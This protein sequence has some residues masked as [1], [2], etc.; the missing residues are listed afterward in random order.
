MHEDEHVQTYNHPQ[1]LLLPLRLHLIPIS[2]TTIDRLDKVPPRITFP[3][4]PPL[5]IMVSLKFDDCGK[6]VTLPHQLE[7]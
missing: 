7:S 5:S 2:R 4:N 1:T 3:T 6:R